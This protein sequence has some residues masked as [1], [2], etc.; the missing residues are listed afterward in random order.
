M[1]NTYF[2]SRSQMLRLNLVEE[3]YRPP[4]ITIPGLNS[5]GILLITETALSINLLKIL[6]MELL[7]V[8]VWKCQWNEQMKPP[9]PPYWQHLF[10]R[11]VAR[12]KMYYVFWLLP[13]L[14]A[15]NFRPVFLRLAM[16][17]RDSLAAPSLPQ[18]FPKQNESLDPVILQSN[19][20]SV[21]HKFDD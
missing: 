7:T 5:A 1:Q 9:P 18:T 10:E 3:E 6:D 11:K 19:I 17:T 16:D 13:L 21:L 2:G 15:S 14:S 20:I 8:A 4:L 12:R